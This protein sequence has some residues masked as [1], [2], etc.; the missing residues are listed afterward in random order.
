MAYIDLVKPYV[1]QHKQHSILNLLLL[2]AFSIEETSLWVGFFDGNAS[3][4]RATFAAS[5]PNTPTVLSGTL[6]TGVTAIANICSDPV[7]AVRQGQV[8]FWAP[9]LVSLARDAPQGMGTPDQTTNRSDCNQN[10]EI[11]LQPLVYMS[12]HSTEAT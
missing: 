11:H 5:I 4:F 10:L 12:F 8:P 1:A 2:L 3:V 6:G 7:R 9:S